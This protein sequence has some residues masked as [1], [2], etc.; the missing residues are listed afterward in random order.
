MSEKIDIKA[1]NVAEHQ[2]LVCLYFSMLPK[3]DVR[4]KSRNEY[5]EILGRRFGK[6]ANTYKNYKDAYDPYFDSNNRV[7]H[8]TTRSIKDQSGIAFQDMYDRYKDYNP[9]DL[10]S[11]IEEIIELYRVEESSFVSMK[12]GFPDTVHAMIAGQEEI[13]IDGVYTLPEKLTVDRI[14]FITVGGD[15][16]KKEVD[17]KPGFFGIS[18]VIKPP[19]DYGY[20]SKDKYFKFDIKVDLILPEVMKREDFINYED[21]FDAPYIGPELS[22]DPSQAVSSFDNQ[23]AVAVVRAALDKYPEIK[24]KLEKIFDKDFMDRVYGS[25]KMLIPTM[26]EYGKSIDDAVIEG[27]KDKKEEAEED[28]KEVVL[29][30]YGKEDFLKQVFIEE[31]DYDLLVAMLENKKNIILQGAP[32]VGKTFM[33]KRLA[34]SMMGYKDDSRVQMVQFH[35]SYSYEDFV[36]GYR[37]NE[38]GFSIEYGPFYDFCKKAEHRVG[39]H[40]FIIDEINRGNVS[41]IF[42]ELLMLIEK[43]KRNDKLDLLYTKEAFSVPDNV[44]II[45]MMNTADRSL[46]LIDYA[47]RR[48]FAFFDVK[49]AF[50][51]ESFKLEV[52]KTANPKRVNHLISYV[53]KLNAAISS[54]ESLG[55]GFEVGHSYFCN[56]PV[57][58]ETG[59]QDEKVNQWMDMTI[60]YELIPLIKE[61]WFDD[62]DKVSEWSSKLRE[63]KKAEKDD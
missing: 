63:A 55:S 59:N 49:P 35:Q 26:V 11:A 38:T 34:Y 54:D 20:N 19:Y 30:P 46:A 44:F 28:E 60:E 6:S 16:G 62:P 23:K 17:W 53:Q 33:A 21:A 42:G 22:R 3:T 10:Q 2:A 27:V 47:L 31:S 56:A 29:T 39:P 15:T 36:V 41:K 45:G 7:G 51:R 18:H 32:G 13:T 25:V 37:P 50:G 61:Y 48:R 9:D 1:L 58:D 57:A 5:W 43:D 24:E 12:C 52:Q 40:F 14:V 8:K 4:Y